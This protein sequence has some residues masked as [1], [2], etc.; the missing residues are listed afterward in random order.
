MKAEHQ[1][2]IESIAV[3][4]GTCKE[5]CLQMLG[6][7]PELKLIRGHYIC[8]FWGE[9]E[10]WWLK[11]GDDIVDPTDAQFPSKGMGEY[12]EWD[13]TQPEPTGKCP[14]CGGYCYDGRS[15]CSD[16]CET[17]YLAYLNGGGL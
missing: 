13:E 9:R 10:H 17:E 11:D 5:T 7:F 12:I 3:V 14:N 8:P 6:V 1:Q 2:W 15:V 16:K 4:A